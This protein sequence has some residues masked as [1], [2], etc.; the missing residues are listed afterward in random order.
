MGM[1]NC[2]LVSII[3][4][5]YNGGYYL[6]ECL[7]SLQYTTYQPI[8][9]IIVDN[10]STDYSVD[11][12]YKAYPKYIYIK[13]KSNYGYCKGNNIG[14]SKA[15]GEYVVLMNNDIIVEPNWLDKLVNA[16]KIKGLG[17]Y[18]PRILSMDDRTKIDSYGS[19]IHIT[20]IGLSRYS[21]E[22]NFIINK[23]IEEVAYASGATMLIPISIINEIGGLNEIF[24]AYGDDLE[25]CWRGKMF[26]YPSYGISSSIIYHKWGAS[27]GR[28]SKIKNYLV[29]RNRVMTI[30]INYSFKSLV[31]LIFLLFL[32]EFLI[33]LFSFFNG[34]LYEKIKS[35]AD[36]MKFRYDIFKQR[37][38]LQNKRKFSDGYV[39]SLFTFTIHH[40]FFETSLFQF[41]S[42]KIIN[43]LFSF[44]SKFIRL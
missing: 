32:M 23:E 6:K 42:V 1:N 11:I 28:N 44:F 13:N 31:T 21:G 41:S 39:T 5:N 25:W 16:V 37:S 40:S 36:I 24:F 22:T 33:I 20:G 2:S 30:L 34:W 26:G 19:D 8:E 9:I 29:E 4:L 43:K 14:I 27:W 3:I 38:I 7:E 35:Y 15:K 10:N 12:A 17:F 18:S